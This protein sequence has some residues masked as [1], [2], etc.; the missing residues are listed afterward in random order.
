MAARTRGE[1]EAVN[2]MKMPAWNSD[3]IKFLIGTLT[4]LMG[5]LGIA[6]AA[7]VRLYVYRAQTKL[8]EAILKTVAHTYQRRDV[9]DERYR[10]L[11]REIHNIKA[12]I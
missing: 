11:V 7:F 6:L 4:A 12:S 3:D 5:S 8:Q 2:R 1:V 9:A 10:Y